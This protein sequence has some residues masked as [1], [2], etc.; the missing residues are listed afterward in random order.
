MPGLLHWP[1][2]IPAG[3]VLTGPC[4]SMDIFPTLLNA[5]GGGAQEY[6]LDGVDIMPYAASAQ[7]PAP[8][9]LYWELRGQRA[10]RRGP[11]KLVLDG[12][13]VEGVAAEDKV[14][15]AHLETDP[16][17]AH[18]LR[19]QEPQLTAELSAAADTWHEGIEARW[20]QEFAQGSPPVR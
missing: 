4:A 1:G 2:R 19:H 13:Q 11:W 6:E 20:Q 17:E 5:A 10:V 3:Q 8:R 7:P 15:L 14:H 18:N 9:D 12:H 16:A